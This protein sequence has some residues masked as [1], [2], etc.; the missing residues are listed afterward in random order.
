MEDF[1]KDID[2]QHA[3]QALIETTIKQI[4]K[5][6]ELERTAGFG[7]GER[8][9]HGSG[10]F[11]KR[12]VKPVFA[13]FGVMTVCVMVAAMVIIR[14]PKPIYNE[15]NISVERGSQTQKN[16]TEISLKEYEKYLNK[17]LTKW[18]ADYQIEK[19][20]ITVRYDEGGQQILE[21]MAAFY[22]SVDGETVILRVSGSH[23]PAPKELLSGEASDIGK[24]EVYMGITD[25]TNQLEAAFEKE[26]VNCYLL[27]RNMSKNDFEN[28][29]KKLIK[30][31]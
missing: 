20:Y 4:H 12:K 30:N 10:A 16:F 11:G 21:D 8:S 22:L 23:S 6:A 28:I 14:Q 7:S 18:L 1:R 19:S 5:E 26:N 15:M 13:V 29:V 9:A 27:C 2:A 17:N 24:V 31:L 3:S 25:S